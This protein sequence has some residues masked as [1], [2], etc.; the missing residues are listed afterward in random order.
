MDRSDARSVFITGATGF[1]GGRL[2]RRFRDRGDRVRC[3]VRPSSDTADL[4]RIGADLVVGDVTDADALSDA[5]DGIDL[6]YHLAALYRVGIVDEDRLRRVNV[7][8]TR[9]FLDAVERAGTPRAVYVSTTGVLA[10][11]PAGGEVPAEPRPALVASG[12]APTAYQRTK[13]EA[14]VLA[15]DAQD[16]GLPLIIANPAYVYGPGDRDGPSSRLLVDLFTGRLPGLLRDPTTFS[17]VHVDDVVEGLVLAGTDGRVGAE[18]VLSGEP[19]TVNEF[20]GKAAALAG[21]RPPRLRFPVPLA[22]LSGSIMGAITRL[23]GLRLPLDREAADLA[24][25][26]RLVHSHGL[27]TRELGWT[28]RPLDEGL[29]ETVEWLLTQLREAPGDTGGAGDA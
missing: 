11:A 20:V 16:R 24:I 19:A 23:T 27:A 10:P 5:L 7:G 4:E 12:A 14:H 17:Y 25:G 2:A 6:A 18:Y 3:L 28:P 1:I 15:R 26:W 13:R 9:A 29:P 8:G 21:R 22:K